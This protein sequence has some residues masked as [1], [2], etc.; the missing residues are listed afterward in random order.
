MAS[1][2]GH[3]FVGSGG[4]SLATIPEVSSA[5]NIV[6]LRAAP[7]GQG[8][9]VVAGGTDTNVNLGLQAQGTGS[10]AML[11]PLILSPAALPAC[12]V[13]GTPSGTICKSS[14]TTIGLAP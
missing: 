13:A 8:P 14:N 9:V 1:L 2:S 3:T 12:G 6:A 10:I 7:T 4:Q 11:S 5:A